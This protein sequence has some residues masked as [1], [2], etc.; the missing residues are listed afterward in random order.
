VPD[1][2]S[3]PTSTY[4]AEGTIVVSS[5]A[6]GVASLA[7]FPHPYC[8]L[9]DMTTASV[10]STGMSQYT[11]NNPNFYASASLANMTGVL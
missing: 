1:L 3:Y 9:I 4:H 10:A 11:T 6:S 8:T 7:L 2:Y 5:N